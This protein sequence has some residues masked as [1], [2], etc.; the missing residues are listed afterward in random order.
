MIT[1]DKINKHTLEYKCSCG[2]TGECMFKPPEGNVIMLL[3]VKCPMCGSLEHLKLMKYDSEK[4]K[5]LLNNNDSELHWTIV[6]D[7]KIKEEK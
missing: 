3:E 1:V 2:I 4:S 5:K 7:N 6:M